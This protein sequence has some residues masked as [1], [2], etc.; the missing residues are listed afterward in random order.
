M[1]FPA[2]HQQ[3]DIPATW[4]LLPGAEPQNASICGG[5]EP[6]DANGASVLARPR[7]AVGPANN[8]KTSHR[9][10]LDLDNVMSLMHLGS[11]SN[12]H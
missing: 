11:R 6:S 7:H 9:T 4:R 10:P 3:R 8:S 1:N 5:N 12:A 2:G